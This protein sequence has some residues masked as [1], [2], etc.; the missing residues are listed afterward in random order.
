MHGLSHCLPGATACALT[1]LSGVVGDIFDICCTGSRLVPAPFFA[2]FGS[3]LRLGNLRGNRMIGIQLRSFLLYAALSFVS[4]WAVAAD[5]TG[6]ED[7]SK[8]QPTSEIAAG[9]G[10]QLDEK[11]DDTQT[12]ELRTRKARD[13]SGYG[14][15]P[16]GELGQGSEGAPHHRRYGRSP[17][18]AN[19]NLVK[20]DMTLLA[21][22]GVGGLADVQALLRGG[23]DPNVTARDTNGRSA[24]ILASAGGYADTATAL[25]LAGADREY[26][27]SSGMTALN[28]SVLRGRNEVVSLL[29]EYGADVNTTDNNGVTPLMYAVG[30]RNVELLIL[31]IDRDAKLE[32]ISLENKM[33]ALLVAVENGDSETVTLLLD[34]GA[35]VN[36][37]N[38][39][40][41]SPLM[42]AA[43]A[44]NS[45]IV[46][47]LI[48][49]G[50][51]V[52]SRDAKGVT[53]LMLA[54]KKGHT[55]VE[56]LL[57]AWC[58][59]RAH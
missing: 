46:E 18:S 59:S 50:A 38:Q 34:R 58:E 43:E 42:A 23:A 28:W 9:S 20:D 37:T 7:L 51:T 6:E 55:D 35:N 15:G 17:S 4:G 10:S 30:T 25:L 36:G 24:L 53:A 13:G 29:L 33:T 11:G 54:R 5:P 2:F 19:K 44:G 32:A 27:D 12:Q 49:R 39:D 21:A 52:G 31:L 48:A 47:L 22:A 40:G 57:E 26:Q 1:L 45:R 14:G 16:G 8:L 56:Q 3:G 41:Y